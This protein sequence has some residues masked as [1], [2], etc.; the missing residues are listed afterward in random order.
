M[1]E[2]L[3]DP[4][5]ILLSLQKSD[6]RCAGE[7]NRQL[8]LT[9]SGGTGSLQ[10]SWSNSATMADLTD[11][12]AGA[13]SLIV[14]DA[15]GCSASI[16]ETLTDPPALVL[17]LVKTDLNCPGDTVLIDLSASGGTGL[18]NFLWTGG[19]STEDISISQS[20]TYTVSVVDANGC[21]QVDSVS[22]A[23]LG[24]APQLQLTT[25]TLT[26]AHPTAI[27]SVSADVPNT[28]FL[29][30]GAGSF[31]S[32]DASPVIS[33]AGSYTVTATTLA[34]ACTA[35]GTVLVPIDTIRP[36]VVVRSY[37][38]IPCDESRFNF[39]QQAHLRVPTWPLT[40]QQVPEAAL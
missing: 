4:P 38:E 6:P 8:D 17:S 24:S 34:G 7:A 25:D 3:V 22:V 18:L 10:Y 39:Q 20:G 28:Q 14:R 12:P 26:C 35:S 13:Y 19:A 1:S 27:I 32:S 5:A 40:G 9:A 33:A 37:L 23:T 30:S 16:T 2:T 15:N 29:W 36:Q 11:I 21:S 31:S